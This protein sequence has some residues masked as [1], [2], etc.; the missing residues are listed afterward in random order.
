MA[1]ALPGVTTMRKSWFKSLL[2]LGGASLGWVAL[3]AQAIPIHVGL[4]DAAGSTAWTSPVIGDPHGT[5]TLTGWEFDDGAWTDAV[6]TYKHSTAAETGMGVAC[7]QAPSHSACGEQ[8]IG[9]SP[10]QMIDLNI[11]KLTG[12]SSLTINLASVNSTSYP[13]GDET[14]YLL[15][16]TCMVGGD[17]TPTVLA[18]CTDFG[19]QG[20]PQTCSFNL[21][22]AQLL[23]ITDIWVTPSLTDQSGRNDGNIL[24]GAD[25]VLNTVPEPAALGMFGFGLLLLG[26]FMGLR[27]RRAH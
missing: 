21:T 20:S 4:Q 17:C 18:S 13:G 5:L 26:L 16:A 15:G 19:G 9:T 22:F 6:M 11:S 3:S 14:G 23:G 2:L 1:P 24:M 25:F 10:W 8:E 27:R 12:W 7:N